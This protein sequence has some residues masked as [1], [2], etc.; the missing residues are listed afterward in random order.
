[1]TVV[2]LNFTEKSLKNLKNQGF[3]LS[4]CHNICYYY[5]L[6]TYIMT[7]GGYE[8]ALFKENV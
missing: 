1:M 7:E 3:L 5:T 4:I 2:I 6:K 8:I